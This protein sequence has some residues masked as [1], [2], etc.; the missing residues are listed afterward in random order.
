MHFQ[1][2]FLVL[3]HHFGQLCGQGGYMLAHCGG[4]GLGDGLVD[5][6]EHVEGGA[7]E[8]EAAVGHAEQLE[9]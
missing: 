2:N 9:E 6:G 4:V 8:F 7:E 1:L 3:I 5:V